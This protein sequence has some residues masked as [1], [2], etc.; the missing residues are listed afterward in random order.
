MDHRSW[1]ASASQNSPRSS[2]H[3][4]IMRICLSR[5]LR[6]MRWATWKCLKARLPLV[7]LLAHIVARIG[8][9]GFP[10]CA[11][12]TNDAVLTGARASSRDTSIN[13]T[14]SENSP[15]LKTGTCTYR[16]EDYRLKLDQTSRSVTYRNCGLPGSCVVEL[17]FDIV[18]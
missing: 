1:P 7:E 5:G 6:G 18:S 8:L 17:S 10:C 9:P 13:N 11:T 3:G 4:R 14:T 12:Q 2:F 15:R 16:R